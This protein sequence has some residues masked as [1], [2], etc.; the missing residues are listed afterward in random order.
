L[1][2]T[3]KV[4]SILRAA[5]AFEVYKDLFTGQWFLEW[6]SNTV[7]A[8]LDFIF[9]GALGTF[10]AK[11]TA[12]VNLPDNGYTVWADDYG[13]ATGRESS[14]SAND[15]LSCTADAIVEL[16]WD[17]ATSET[18]DIMVRRTDD[19]HCWIIR[20]DEATNTIKLIEVNDGETERGSS[21]QTFSNGTSYRI[22]AH[23]V[24]TQ[25]KTYVQVGGTVTLRAEYGS[26]TYNQTVEGAKVIGFASASEFITWPRAIRRYLENL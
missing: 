2:G 6:V 25:I 8:D 5:G 19:D 26:A 3:T 15:T 20:C 12:V 17:C 21:S 4:G 1:D 22:I 9:L 18:V 7:V 16:T 23:I 10:S 24:G 11:N 13:I 14:P